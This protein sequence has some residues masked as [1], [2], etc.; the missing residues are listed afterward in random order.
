[1]D[2][3]H[4]RRKIYADP[5]T[6][7][8][9]VLD[10]Q[11]RDPAKKEFTQ[12]LVQL[13]EKIKKA[14]KVPVPE[15]LCDKL[16][17]RQTLACHQQKKRQSRLQLALVAS[18][19]IIAGV[20]I[21]FFQFSSS[22]TNLGDYALAHVYHEENAF[23][24]QDATRLNLTTLNQKMFAFNG[25]FNHLLGELI[26]ADYCRFDGMKSLHLVY[27]GVTDTVAVFIVPKNEQLT[28]SKTFSD[29]KLQGESIRFKNTNIIVVA[30]KNEP[31]SK[32][33]KS[34]SENISWST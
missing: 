4:F 33:K 22:Y 5:N 31:I 8:K 11:Q 20:V 15:N 29:K 26:F 34:I 1:M 12:E 30:D 14:M 6:Q 19:A 25:S 32:W 16:I 23:S 24:N 21:N 13:D 10:A 3:L 2:D 27:K 9:A 17:L 28:F 18:V 7:D